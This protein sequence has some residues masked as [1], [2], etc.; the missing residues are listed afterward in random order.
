V[1]PGEFRQ[2]AA[3][4]RRH[5]WFRGTRRVILDWA[6]SVGEGD[7]ESRYVADIG[8]GTGPTLDWLREIPS[9][10]GV[11]LSPVALGLAQEATEANL[12]RGN[13]CALPLANESMDMILAL[14]MFEHL[15]SPEDAASEIFRTLKP[16]GWLVSTVPAWPFLASQHDVALG[17]YRRYRRPG[18]RSLLEN[19]GFSV[20]RVSY[21]N[22]FLFPA[23]AGIRLIRSE[24][25]TL[26]PSKEQPDVESD[27]KPMPAFMNR[28]LEEL[29]ASEKYLLRLMDLP[30]G[31]SLIARAQRPE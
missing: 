9:V 10:V 25:V 17:H 5:F 2:M 1:T 4:M 22:F 27:L 3:L 8:C 23:V 29:L 28:M 14:D 13:A 16:G 6:R 24:S 30:F 15:E 26:D 19:A 21:Y 20:D 11:D 12:V 31:V 18:F 7:L